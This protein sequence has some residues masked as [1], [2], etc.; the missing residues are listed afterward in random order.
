ML[1]HVQLCPSCKG[2]VV[3]SQVIPQNAWYIGCKQGLFR[4]T[5]DEPECTVKPMLMGQPTRWDAIAA[6][7]AYALQQNPSTCQEP[8][9]CALKS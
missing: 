2:G 3:I 5:T 8:V 6:W 4:R 9:S 7:N 1:E